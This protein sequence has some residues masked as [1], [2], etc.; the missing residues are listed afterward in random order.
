VAASFGNGKLLE[1]SEM[2]RDL[3]LKR[4]RLAIQAGKIL[5]GEMFFAGSGWDRHLVH[6]LK[7]HGAWQ[8][9][10]PSSRGVFFGGKLDLPEI[11]G[12]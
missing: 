6:S 8:K 10:V 12:R 11:F 5:K 7:W 4:N 1:K 9:D 2:P 3:Y